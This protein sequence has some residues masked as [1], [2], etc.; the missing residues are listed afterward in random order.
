MSDSSST[1]V[2]PDISPSLITVS[3]EKICSLGPRPL[4]I[5]GFLR[6]I[7]I[8]HFSDPDGIDN[9]C[10]KSKVWTGSL[11][12][13]SAPDTKLVIETSGRWDPKLVNKRPGL[14]L[15]RNALQTQRLGINNKLMGGPDLGPEYFEQL[16]VGSHTINAVSAEEAEAEELAHEVRG[17]L[18]GFANPLRQMLDLHRFM[19]MGAGPPVPVREAKDLTMV[20]VSVMYAFT[21]RVKV[22][23]YEPILKRIQIEAIA[24]C[25]D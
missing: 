15:Q 17:Q 6:Q 13:N 23:Q 19:V 2:S 7:L 10:L 3:T 4:L 25:N 9:P 16:C 22:H 11:D 20:Q 18:W 24:G 1:F 8:Q 14:F 21:E 12:G 5:T